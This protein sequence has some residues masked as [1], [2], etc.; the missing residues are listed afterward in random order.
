[1][2]LKCGGEESSGPLHFKGTDIDDGEEVWICLN[3]MRQLIHDEEYS[4]F[5][6]EGPETVVVR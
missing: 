1:M 4:R 2:H 6:P 5:I 3:C